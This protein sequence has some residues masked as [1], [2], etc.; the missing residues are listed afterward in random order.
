MSKEPV[1]IESPIL[2]NACRVVLTR[3]NPL[4]DIEASLR[5]LFRLSLDERQHCHPATNFLLS[6]VSWFEYPYCRLHHLLLKIARWHR[7]R[8][9]ETATVCY[10]LIAEGMQSLEWERAADCLIQLSELQRD[11]TLLLAS[12]R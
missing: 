12:L 5:L 7:G 6:R 1:L 2:T 3:S 4:Q 10:N 8:C 9:P 11:H